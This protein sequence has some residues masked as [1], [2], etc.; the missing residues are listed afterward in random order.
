MKSRLTSCT[1]HVHS[2]I[3]LYAECIRARVGCGCD[4]DVAQLVESK[5]TSTVQNDLHCSRNLAATALSIVYTTMQALVANA[6]ITACCGGAAS[7]TARI[8]TPL[9]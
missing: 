9:I 6:A 4:Q 5:E 2:P 7:F 8:A 1:R 3:S